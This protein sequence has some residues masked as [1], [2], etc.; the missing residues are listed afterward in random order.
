[1]VAYM[2]V[3]HATSIVSPFFH[4]DT[5]M[6]DEKS[7]L[8]GLY[9]CL[10]YD[11][12]PLPHFFKNHLVLVVT[13]KLNSRF[14]NLIRA[15]TFDEQHFQALI[16]FLSYRSAFAENELTTHSDIHLPINHWLD[17][18][19]SEKSLPSLSETTEAINDL[20]DDDTQYL[21]IKELLR[22]ARELQVKQ[23]VHPNHWLRAF[24]ELRI[25]QAIKQELQSPQETSPTLNPEAQIDQ[26][27]QT[28]SNKRKLTEEVDTFFEQ[29]KK[30]RHDH[31]N[32]VSAAPQP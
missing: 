23:G 5:L 30:T 21:D 27:P 6:V 14:S 2:H 7:F 10:H 22:K 9:Q 20:K 12:N 13:R 26:A 11:L 31:L 3:F 28:P 19:K 8:D 1:M 16:Q 18:S 32:T 24:S 4:E 29:N 25:A 15:N 17:R